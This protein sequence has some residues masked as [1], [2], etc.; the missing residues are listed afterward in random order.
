MKISII[1]LK[2]GEWKINRQIGNG[3]FA[4]VYE[5]V[6]PSNETSALKLV[7]KVNGAKREFLLAGSDFLKSA[8]NVV[9]ILEDGEI[10]EHYVLRMPLAKMSLRDKLNESGR[11]TTENAIPILKDIVTAISSFEGNVVHRDLKP[12]NILLIDDRW[13]ISDFGISKYAEASTASDTRK[14]AKT[15]GYAA[16]EQWLLQSATS[17]TDIYAFGVICYEMLSGKKPFEGSEDELREKHVNNKPPK[18]NVDPT[19]EAIIIQCLLKTPGSRPSAKNVLTRIEKF[20]SNPKNQQEEPRLRQALAEVAN[21]R[22]ES[23]ASRL[24]NEEAEKRHNELFDYAGTSLNEIIQQFLQKLK[25]VDYGCNVF[26]SDTFRVQLQDAEIFLM[27]PKPV[28][29]I[30]WGHYPPKF[31][32]IAHAS[33]SVSLPFEETGRSPRI[34]N[35]YEG[36]S[37]S[38]WYC[39]AQEA[40]QFRWF[41]F[42]FIDHPL[43][44][45]YREETPF[46]LEP[47]REVNAVFSNTLGTIEL[48]NKIRPIDQGEEDNFII[49]W[50]TFLAEAAAGKLKRPTVKPEEDGKGSYRTS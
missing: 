48:N 31:E 39:D 20:M 40:G 5:C 8:S 11:F 18:I 4:E 16:P 37:C 27:P 23:E 50:T 33:L 7:T 44:E 47:G 15:P 13:C 2:S 25:E 45:N 9:P 22:A 29:D 49:R 41:E 1:R 3:G 36:R 14:F 21:V 28:T 26:P 17:A 35:N 46:A 10:D 6:G 43:R 19:I 42:S 32:V 38:L 12:E 34:N 24:A 30:D